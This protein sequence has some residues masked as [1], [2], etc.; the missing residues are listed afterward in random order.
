MNLVYLT[1]GITTIFTIEN[2]ILVGFFIARRIE[3]PSRPD[4]EKIERRP[5]FGRRAKHKPF[6]IS[7]EEQ[8]RR[9]QDERK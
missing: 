6:A 8:Y 7:D 4:P 2:A 3:T 9:E 1:A 5:V